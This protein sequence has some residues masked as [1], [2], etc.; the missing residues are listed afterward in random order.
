MTLK[1]YFT[2]IDDTYPTC[3]ECRAM[4]CIYSDK[5]P[6]EISKTLGLAPTD[7]SFVGEVKTNSLGRS[8]VSHRNNW[9]L[10]SETFVDSKDLRRHLDWILGKLTPHKDQ[11]L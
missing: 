2:P 11:L 3:E 4:L 7:S 6:D 9:F 1:S 10:S 5:H 8:R